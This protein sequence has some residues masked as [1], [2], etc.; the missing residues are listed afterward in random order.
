MASAVVSLLRETSVLAYTKM[1]DMVRGMVVRFASEES[2]IILD[3]RGEQTFS[4]QSSQEIA[5]TTRVTERSRAASLTSVGPSEGDKGT[6][7]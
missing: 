3:E 4:V 1:H 5:A 7:P 2:S 6:V